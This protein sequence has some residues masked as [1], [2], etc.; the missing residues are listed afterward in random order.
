MNLPIDIISIETL[1]DK[2]G[3]SKMDIFQI[4]LNRHLLPAKLA[5]PHPEAELIEYDFLDAVDLFTGEE[6]YGNRSIIFRVSDVK[7][8]E[9]KLGSK[10]SISD[11]I[12]SGEE[13]CKRWNVSMRDRK[14][15]RR[16]PFRSS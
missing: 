3:M 7:K 5:H 15:N 14:P 9:R 2:W 6:E 12:I 16:I 1:M 10:C 4:V 8:L 13:L 11:S